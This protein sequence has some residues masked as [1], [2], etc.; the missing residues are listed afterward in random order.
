M[1]LKL[2]NKYI[3]LFLAID[4]SAFRT[5]KKSIVDNRMFQFYKSLNYI[6]F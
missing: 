1:F 6:I 3:L 2:N 4:V 5:H